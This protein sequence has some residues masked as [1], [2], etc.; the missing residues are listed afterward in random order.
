MT[1]HAAPAPAKSPVDIEGRSDRENYFILVM[2]VLGL[3][4]LLVHTAGLKP[5]KVA[6]PPSVNGPWR[7]VR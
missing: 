3:V 4:S 1:E 7:P 2:V 6:P 5:K